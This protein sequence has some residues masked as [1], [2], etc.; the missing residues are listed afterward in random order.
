MSYKDFESL[1]SKGKNKDPENQQ[2]IDSK[3]KFYSIIL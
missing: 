3:T 2:Q 1:S